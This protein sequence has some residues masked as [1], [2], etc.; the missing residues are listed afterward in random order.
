M[1]L[2]SK[3]TWRLLWTLSIA[4]MMVAALG[5]AVSY[6]AT[7]RAEFYAAQCA[8]LMAENERLK[9]RLEATAVERHEVVISVVEDMGGKKPLAL[10]TR[11]YLNIKRSA[12][13][14]RWEGELSYDAAGHV[15]FKDAAYSIRAGAI[16]LKNYEKKHGIK[17]V[18]GII[19]RF[20]EGNREAY[21][22]H[23]CK[24]LGVQPDEEISIAERLPELLR[25]M[26]K[27]ET[28]MSLAEE[29][30]ALVAAVME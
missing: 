1:S 25:A 4:S 17:T 26:V 9:E 3:K 18:R 10:A 5:L 13:G 22:R 14:Q 23:V 27:F 2:A 29:H 19:T 15:I 30:L 24:A 7:R 8:L 28:G 21:I 11:N 6:K 16:V 20:A 12:N